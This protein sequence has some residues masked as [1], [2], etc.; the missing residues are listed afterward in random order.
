M[1]AELSSSIFAVNGAADARLI[2]VTQ[3]LSIEL[4]VDSNLET[5]N[6]NQTCERFLK[7]FLTRF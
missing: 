4:K 7:M 2:N 3:V 6:C 1:R 5:S